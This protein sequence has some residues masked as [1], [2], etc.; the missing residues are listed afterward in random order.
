MIL[1]SFHLKEFS[2]STRRDEEDRFFLLFSI[3]RFFFLFIVKSLRIFTLGERIDRLYRKLVLN[4]IEGKVSRKNRSNN[5]F[6]TT[7]SGFFNWFEVFSGTKVDYEYKIRGRCRE[8]C[9]KNVEIYIS[10]F[11]LKIY[12][13]SIIL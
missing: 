2:F 8:F 6:L 7:Q 12:N 11:F 13:I 10:S 5:P 3:L 9:S 1:K 4:M